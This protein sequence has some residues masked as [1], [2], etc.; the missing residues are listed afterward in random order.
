MFGCCVGCIHYSFVTNAD[1]VDAADAAAD[2]AVAD[3]SVDADAGMVQQLNSIHLVLI[4][5]T[6]VV[7]ALQ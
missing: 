3:T 1:D 7:A 4:Q 5:Y 6:A 2:D